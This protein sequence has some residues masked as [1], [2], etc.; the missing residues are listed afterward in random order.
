MPTDVQAA[1]QPRLL[2]IRILLQPLQA[3]VLFVQVRPHNGVHR[4]VFQVTCGVLVQPRNVL[5]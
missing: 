2:L 3:A 1:L 4:Q 5:L